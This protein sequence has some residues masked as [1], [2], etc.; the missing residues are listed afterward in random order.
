MQVLYNVLKGTHY[1]ENCVQS[2]HYLILVPVVYQSQ[3]RGMTCGRI[4]SNGV[5]MYRA[6][7]EFVTLTHNRIIVVMSE[8]VGASSHLHKSLCEM[9]NATFSL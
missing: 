4:S 7:T 5:P 8:G 9:N 1:F 6:H 3:H 2:R